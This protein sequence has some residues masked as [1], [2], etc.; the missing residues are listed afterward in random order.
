[1]AAMK[2]RAPYTVVFVAA[3]AGAAVVVA[4]V[5]RGPLGQ[6]SV[7]APPA[8]SR[9][10]GRAEAKYPPA[11]LADACRKAAE[12]LRD[13]LDETF[14]VTV[15][16]PFVVAG[17]CSA[18]RLGGYIKWSVVRPAEAM[19]KSYFEKKPTAVITILLFADGRSYKHWAKELFG[20]TDLPHFGYCRRDGVLVMNIATGTGTLVHE[21]THALI[22]YDFPQVPDWF[23][24]GLSSLHEQCNVRDDVVVGLVN[25][26]LPGLQKALRE[27]SLRP[28]RQLVTADDFYGRLQGINYAQARYFVM[29]MQQRGVLAKFYKTFRDMHA[30]RAKAGR[31]DEPAEAPIDVRA[32][33]QTFGCSVDEIDAACRKWVMTLRFQ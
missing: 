1:M 10:A 19:W 3:L 24:E 22:K 7:A 21:L 5:W 18:E 26:R 13:R 31:R 32:I 16:P 23:N 14:N 20:D 29:Y 11:E 17:N 8:A 9:P 6:P 2:L 15:R 30:E 12:K 33:E 28:L 27:G 25:W 4:H